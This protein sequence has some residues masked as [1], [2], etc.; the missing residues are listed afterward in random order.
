MSPDRENNSYEEEQ[1]KIA[2]NDSAMYDWFSTAEKFMA[3]I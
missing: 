3:Y 2:T 1:K